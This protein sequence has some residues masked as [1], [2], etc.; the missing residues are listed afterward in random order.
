MA[1]LSRLIPGCGYNDH[2]DSLGF[3]YQELSV[4]VENRRVTMVGAEDEATARGLMGWL[5][6]KITGS[7]GQATKGGGPGA[8]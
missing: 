8:R 2:G 4:L 6:D 1:G 3:H 7:E 5:N